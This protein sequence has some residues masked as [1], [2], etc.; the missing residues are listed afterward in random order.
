M[1]KDKR[2]LIVYDMP[3]GTKFL[4][5]AVKSS[6][7]DTWLE[8][9]NDL[10]QKAKKA[11]S[12]ELASRVRSTSEPLESKKASFRKDRE[13]SK[14]KAKRPSSSSGVRTASQGS[15]VRQ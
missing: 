10:I 8:K 6:V 5:R 13:G 4:L 15:E 7:R 11:V 14:R 2:N 9:S 12:S 1:D 3:T